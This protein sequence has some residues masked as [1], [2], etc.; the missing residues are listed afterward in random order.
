MDVGLGYP[1]SIVRPDGKVMAN[2][3]FNASRDEDRTIQ[4]TF[5]TPPL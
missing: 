2:Y 4:A 1:R 3:Y 5:W